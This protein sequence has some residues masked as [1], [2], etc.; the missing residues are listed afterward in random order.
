[1]NNTYE[2]K[3]N[4]YCNIIYCNKLALPLVIN[5]DGNRQSSP[6]L[7]SQG[8]PTTS[9]SIDFPQPEKLSADGLPLT[10]E[11]YTF[12]PDTTGD[13]LQRL[14]ANGMMM[15]V[16]QPEDISPIFNQDEP[17]KTS[18][19]VNV[20]LGPGTNYGIVDTVDPG[21]TG[22][23]LGDDNGLN[24]VW[25]KG[26]YWWRVLLDGPGGVDIVGWVIEPALTVSTNLR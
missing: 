20:R 24:G 6:D 3:N 5:V 25:A 18:T 22:K 9:S 8:V 2:V 26:Y 19:R 21:T 23:I 4:S 12:A 10:E 17:I 14:V 15:V 7:Q 11:Y 16:V 13:I 1:M